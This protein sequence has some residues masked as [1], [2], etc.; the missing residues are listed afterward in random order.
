MTPEQV[1]DALNLLPSDLI[2]EADKLRDPK[3][4][5][6]VLRTW[7]ATAACAALV[8]ILGSFT[9]SNFLPDMAKSTESIAKAPAAA[10]PRD[11][12]A[13]QI[14]SAM[15]TV[16][17][18]PT[19]EAEEEAPDEKAQGENA[20]T[21]D[22]GIHLAGVQYLSTPVLPSVNTE[23]DPRTDLITSREALDQYLE[24]KSD[25]YHMDAA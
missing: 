21:M 1:H 14:E 18:M 12:M 10:A 16:T 6:L 11:E 13:Q 3:R 7:V 5:P 23:G 24:R 19:A 8:L 20:L 15:D 4:K 2:T 22:A 9:I 25:I 17:D